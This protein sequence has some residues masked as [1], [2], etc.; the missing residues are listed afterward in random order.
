M[1]QWSPK[2]GKSL[3]KEGHIGEQP[4][5]LAASFRHH[6]GFEKCPNLPSRFCM[7][8]RY[9]YKSNHIEISLW[10]MLV[11]VPNVFPLNPGHRKTYKK[12]HRSQTSVRGLRKVVHN[13]ELLKLVAILDAILDFQKCSRVSWIHPA[14]FV[15]VMSEAAESSEKKLYQSAQGM[16]TWG[17]HQ[18]KDA[19][20]PV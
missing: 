7:S 20:L 11:M 10:Y 9:S 4:M 13:C 1:T 8:H 18:Y 19:V 17:P 6:L 14:D 15:Y 3:Q 5:E 16:L 12:T 2:S